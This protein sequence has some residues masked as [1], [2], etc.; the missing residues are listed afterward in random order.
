MVRVHSLCVRV[1]I[2][3]VVAVDVPAAAV[4][5]GVRIASMLIDSRQLA[6]ALRTPSLLLLLLLVV[7]RR[8]AVI[9]PPLR[10]K[11]ALDHVQQLV[12]RGL[13]Q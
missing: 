5:N 10:L 4:I 7:R 9:H 2:P 8:D 6:V 12:Q 13:W 3:C 11:L 1:G